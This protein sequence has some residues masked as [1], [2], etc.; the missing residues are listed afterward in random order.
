MKP[1]KSYSCV[2][3]KTHAIFSIAYAYET[4]TLAPRKLYY[5][6]R[7]LDFRLN[8]HFLFRSYYSGI[9]TYFWAVIAHKVA[10]NEA[11]QTAVM[12]VI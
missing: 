6:E 12:R 1:V 4:V 9:F 3:D 8:I 11:G 10:S 5:E 2:I 7:A